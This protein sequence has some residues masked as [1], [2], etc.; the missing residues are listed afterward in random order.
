MQKG[1]GSL[2]KFWFCV[3]DPFETTHNLGRVVDRERYFPLS[4][5]FFFF[6]LF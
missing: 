1:R 2:D 3:E 6:F 4:S 5:P